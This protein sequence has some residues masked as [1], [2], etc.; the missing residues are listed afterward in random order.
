MRSDE[1]SLRD[2]EYLRYGRQL[3]LAEIGEEGQVRLKAKSVPTPA[4]AR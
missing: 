4:P 2:E 1:A 3:M